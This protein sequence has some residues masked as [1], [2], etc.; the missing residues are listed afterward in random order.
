MNYIQVFVKILLTDYSS[1][2]RVCLF[3]GSSKAMARTNLLDFSPLFIGDIPCSR[4][5]RTV[6]S[7]YSTQISCSISKEQ[8]STFFSWRLLSRL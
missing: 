3:V 8:R 2:W 5:I 6:Y 7:V 4:D 1:S